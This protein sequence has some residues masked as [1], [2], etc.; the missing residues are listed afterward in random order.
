[1]HTAVLTL[2]SNFRSATA[3]ALLISYFYL[4]LRVFPP[5][6]ISSFIAQ[7]F[8]LRLFAFNFFS[9]I[10]V[11]FLRICS[12]SSRICSFA[13]V[14]FFTTNFCLFTRRLALFLRCLRYVLC[15]HAFKLTSV[16]RRDRCTAALLARALFVKHVRT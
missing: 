16:R 15:F 8:F 6:S 13:N 2:L 5:A 12:Y 11:M 9:F 4:A 3:V 14:C 7:L 10:S 1:M